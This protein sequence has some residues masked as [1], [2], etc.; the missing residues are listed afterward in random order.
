MIL[1]FLS[2]A[3]AE[4]LPAAPDPAVVTEADDARA[5][6][7]FENGAALYDEG[8]YEDAIAAWRE[9]WRLSGRPLLLFNMANA[10]ERLARWSEAAALLN[11]YRAFAPQEEREVLERRIENIERRA[12]AAPA[13]PSEAPARRSAVLPIT[14]FAAGGAGLVTGTVFALNALDAREAAGDLCA[15]T[16]TGTWCPSSASPDIARDRASALGADVA[17]G[18]SLGAIA[19]GVVSLVL[20]ARVGVG[21]HVGPTGGLVTLGG[22]LP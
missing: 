4:T 13:L 18:L 2:A 11:R 6:E 3:R 1:L 14:L 17:F 20:P 7:L 10:A 5:R 15:T 21:L 8:R 22:A 12:A 16:G 19:G 9:A